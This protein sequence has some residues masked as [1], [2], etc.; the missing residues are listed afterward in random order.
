MGGEDS[1]YCS[2]F[3]AV[4]FTRFLPFRPPYNKPEYIAFGGIVNSTDDVLDGM[5]W[6]D[7]DGSDNSFRIGVNPTDLMNNGTSWQ[8]ETMPHPRVGG[9]SVTLPNGEILIMNGA[10]KGT[11]NDFLREPVREAVMYD[12]DAP[13]GQRYRTLATSPIKRLYHN[14]A[15]LLPTGNVLVTGGEQGEAYT[16]EGGGPWCGT[17][18]DYTYEA[19]I[20]KPPYVYQP[21]LRPTIVRVDG[22]DEHEFGSTMRVFFEKG[23]NVDGATITSPPA[24]THGLEMN[25]RTAFLE[26]VGGSSGGKHS[27][28]RRRDLSSEDDN[29][30]DPPFIDLVLPKREHRVTVSG[31]HMLFLLNDKSP[32]KEAI[33]I[34]ILEKRDDSKN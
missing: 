4:G 20:Y 5:C 17:S 13:V 2:A 24:V 31:W 30:D 19:E 23:T 34:N 10:K 27:N 21:K 14:E 26:V 8:E 16:Q 7:I 32:S 29:D 11:G 6:S 18:Y 33:W 25:S 1:D 9:L 22:G 3:S 15:I 12:P 28:L